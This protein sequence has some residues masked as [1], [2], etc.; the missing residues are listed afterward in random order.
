MDEKMIDQTQLANF[1]LPL[2]LL[3]ASI[4]KISFFSI[5]NSSFLFIF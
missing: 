4:V 2:K 1:S 5:K 3:F